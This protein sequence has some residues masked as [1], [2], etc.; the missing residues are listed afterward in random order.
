VD[1]GVDVGKHS[2]IAIHPG[3]PFGFGPWGIGIAYHDATNGSLKYATT[4]DPQGGPWAVHTIERGISSVSTT[5]LYPSLKFSD[6][7]NP[8]IAHYFDNPTNVDAL[9]LAYYSVASGNCESGDLPDSWRCETIIT[10]EGVGQYPSLADIDEF[11]FRVAYYDEGRGDLWYA[12]S[13]GEGNC[14][15][16]G[17]DWSCYPISSATNV[18]QYASLYLDSEDRFHI[19]YYDAT[20]HR[21]KYAVEV[22]SGGNCGVLGSAQ[23][24]EIDAMMQGYNPLGL[25]IAEDAA[26]YPIIAYQSADRSLNVARP[27]AAVGLPAGSGNCGPEVPLATWY[28]ETIDSPGIWIPYR[29]GDYVSIAVGPS[30]LA[31]IAYYGFILSS[32]GNLMVAYQRVQVYLPLVVRS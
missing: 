26:G 16:Y 30:G 27:L 9:K 10:G 8:V 21:L 17:T 6:S 2:S 4:Q 23:C 32:G 1:S 29:N 20:S 3:Y 14:G 22:E 25:S 28:C 18:G 12:T 5:G 31:T 24:D 7:G 13:V 15:P 19:A 11:E